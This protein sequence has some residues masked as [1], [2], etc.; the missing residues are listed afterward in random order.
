[1]AALLGMAA[2]A[3]VGVAIHRTLSDDL[4]ISRVM[5]FESKQQLLVERAL[6]ETQ[7]DRVVVARMHNG[8]SVMQVG[9]KKN[10]SIVAEAHEDYMQAA[11]A[12]HQNVGMD[13]QYLGLMFA[14]Q[15]S[16]RVFIETHK[17]EPSR[18][19]NRYES[20]GVKEALFFLLKDTEHSRYFAVFSSQSDINS[21]GGG[22]TSA[23]DLSRI[24]GIIDQLRKLY[25]KAAQQ[26]ILH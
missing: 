26:K 25:D 15:E 13:K 2:S 14:L 12:E 8:G 24:E 11:F 5:A 3:L 17:L 16:D 20:E 6:V 18:L 7:A 1:M 19:K 21:P 10:G 23:H 4:R 22:I 9:S